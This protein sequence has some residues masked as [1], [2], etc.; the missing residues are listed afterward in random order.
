MALIL[1]FIYFII[2]C[3]IHSVKSAKCQLKENCPDERKFQSPI[4]IITCDTKKV[5]FPPLR[6]DNLNSAAD[7]TIKNT[8]TTLEAS[9][10]QNGSITGG[11]LQK[12][13][14]FSQLHFHWSCKTGEGSEHLI[15]GRRYAMEG[16]F[17]FSRSYEIDV[18][19]TK[20]DE[21]RQSYYYNKCLEVN[22]SYGNCTAE[23]NDAIVFNDCDNEINLIHSCDVEAE[24]EQRTEQ[25]AARNA[26][27]QFVSWIEQREPNGNPCD[28]IET[29]KKYSDAA[30]Q[31][32]K[33]TVTINAVLAVF[34]VKSEIAPKY[35]LLDKARDVVKVNSTVEE[36]GKFISQF[37]NLLNLKDG[38]YTYS[39]SLTT[40]PFDTNVIWLV[41]PQPLLVKNA[42]VNL[43][44][45]LN[46]EEGG[47][48][49]ENF[50]E[51]QKLYDRVVCRRKSL[52]NV[53]FC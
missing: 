23:N 41:L 15:N 42:Q 2:F 21:I 6:L 10:A 1:N 30:A 17:V 36:R 52:I 45:K 14:S 4:D 50:R 34:F 46:S 7:V 18:S 25:I 48:I 32:S 11:L 13:Y 51:I 3:S 8:G 9:Q 44:C 5:D 31:F 37:V 47:L 22:P 49:E 26:G 16:H 20:L 27:N 39:G 29:T 19:T 35:D 28:K 33:Q 40:P 24:T 38:F 43:L 12:V 53:E